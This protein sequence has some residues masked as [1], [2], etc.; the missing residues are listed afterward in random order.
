ML[1]QRVETGWT[2]LKWA[3]FLKLILFIEFELVKRK[4]EIT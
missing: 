4:V 2:E 1:I 3:T